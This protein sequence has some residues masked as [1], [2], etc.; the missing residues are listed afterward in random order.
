M[1]SHLLPEAQKT[2]G[3]IDGL[4]DLNNEIEALLFSTWRQ[5]SEF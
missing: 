5:N 2:A 4:A 3:K 1:E